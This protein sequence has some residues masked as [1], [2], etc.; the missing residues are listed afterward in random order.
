MNQNTINMNII[1]TRNLEIQ[2]FILT[3]IYTHVWY[4]T[5]WMS[6][7]LLCNLL[8]CSHSLF[9]NGEETCL[10]HWIFFL[11]SIYFL[12][13]TGVELINNVVCFR[14]T[15][16][17]FSYTY[18]YIR[19]FPY[20]PSHIDYYKVSSEF[21]VLCSRAL[22]VIYFIYSIVYMFIWNS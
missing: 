10:S 19:S 7:T 9:F 6:Y 18:T 21:P 22:L 16:K 5:V 1:Q 17:L 13:Y 20:F 15:E 4:I 2:S 8:C 3:A 11:F 14:C 12:F